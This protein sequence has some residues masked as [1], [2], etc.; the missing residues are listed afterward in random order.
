MGSKLGSTLALYDKNNEDEIISIILKRNSNYFSVF[1]SF[2]LSLSSFEH[3]QIY[4]TGLRGPKF[5]W[6]VPGWY[7]AGWWLAVSVETHGCT[8]AQLEELM[9]Y[10]I[11]VTG[12]Q[13]V[14]NLDKLDYHGFVSACRLN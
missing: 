9:R 4:K 7:A 3:V 10:H 8:V 6:I 12:V 2:I 11:V 1:Y 5:V 14:D 13:I